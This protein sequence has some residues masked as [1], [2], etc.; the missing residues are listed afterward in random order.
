[1]QRKARE[2][3]SAAIWKSPIVEVTLSSHDPLPIYGF[4]RAHPPR[5]AHFDFHARL[6]R[7]ESLDLYVALALAPS[8]LSPVGD[9]S[10]MLFSPLFHR[11]SV[12]KSE[13]FYGRDK[14]WENASYVLGVARFS[15]FW[16]FRNVWY[17]ER[18]FSWKDWRI[19]R[20]DSDKWIRCL[21][22]FSIRC[23]LG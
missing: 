9:A 8:L 15:S 16:C 19:N 21:G 18:V 4:S 20:W 14:T 17:C 11:S 5:R 6:P 10:R 7:R 1:M 13:F 12:F 2:W 3:R 22:N 23:I